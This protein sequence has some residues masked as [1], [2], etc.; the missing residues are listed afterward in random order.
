[1]EKVSI[2]TFGNTEIAFK[3]MNDWRLKKAFWMFS[4]VKNPTVSKIMITLVQ[5]FPIKRA[6]KATVFDHFCGGET[7]SESKDSI[8]SLAKY[9]VQTILDY[10]V[11]GGNNE[12][13]FDDVMKE[14]IRTIEN[15]ANYEEI[16]F[17]V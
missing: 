15:A 17:A 11:E 14:V 16:P 13:N 7:I 9:K 4:I 12:K 10:S 8:K 2:D 1:M 5:L 3:Y 6:I